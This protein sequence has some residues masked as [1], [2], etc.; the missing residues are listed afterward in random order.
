M[1]NITYLIG[2]G[3]SAYSIPMVYR[4]QESIE[5]IFRL[6]RNYR[7]SNLLDEPIDSIAK[8]MFENLGWLIENIAFHSTIDT[9]AKKLYI[10]RNR[11]GLERF[12][13]TISILF[14]FEEM[15]NKVDY[16]YDTFFASILDSSLKLPSN[17]KILS[18]NYDLQ[19]ERAFTSYSKRKLF[20]SIE[21]LSINFPNNPNDRYKNNFIHKINGMIWFTKEL[22][23][24]LNFSQL[25][26]VNDDL[27]ESIIDVYGSVLKDG[28]WERILFSWENYDL[29]KSRIFEI[30]EDILNTNI[31]VCIG[32]SFPYFNRNVDTYLIKSMKYL[33]K[34]Y[35]QNPQTNQNIERFKTIRN[36]LND[37]S[38]IAYENCTEFLLPDEL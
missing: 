37:K 35:F 27:T 36:D 20:Q 9:F 6:I 3:A 12:K 4:I 5:L 16:R 38:F 1:K 11:S 31:L 25:Y 29:N 21:E 7:E 33:E 28:L 26:E 32:Y 14:L 22:S 19:F 24:E 18:W 10:T 30:K 15:R 17:V 13:K 2:A 23:D 34:I 8:E